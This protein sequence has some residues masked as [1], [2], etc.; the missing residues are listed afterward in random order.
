MILL[1][2]ASIGL[3]SCTSDG[4]RLQKYQF[5]RLRM[6]TRANLVIHAPDPQS[7]TQAAEAAFARMSVIED[8]LS[9]WQLDSEVSRLRSL[10]AGRANPISPDLDRVLASSI[11]ISQ[12]SDGA[13]DVT[14]G[15]LTQLW[16]KARQEGVPPEEHSIQE[17]HS[18]IGW[19]FIE[20]LPGDQ[21]PLMISRRSS[22]WLDFGGIGKGYAADEALAV[23]RDRGLASS[24]VELGGDM[25]LGLPPPNEPGWRITA[26][27]IEETLVL[28]QC[29]VATSGSTDQF[30]VVDGQKWS[31]LLDPRTGMAVPDR[32]SFTVVAPDATVADGWASVAAVVG[33]EAARDMVHSQQGILFLTSTDPMTARP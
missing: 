10:P 17:A 8:A 6:G 12:A 27:G 32:G 26:I 20:R 23:L 21:G 5:S 24:L 7:A 19:Q 18:T 25:A 14:C 11:E 3:P 15:Q 1:V 33:I 31:H 29:G 16:R 30:L 22:P 4:Q 2:L 13:F 28:S 9:D